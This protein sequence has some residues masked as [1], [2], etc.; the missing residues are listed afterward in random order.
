MK[1]LNYREKLLDPRWQQ[2]RLQVLARDG[3]KCRICEATDKTLHAH[4]S[5]Y[6][7]WAEGPWDYV[8]ETIITLCCDCHEEETE[9]LKSA[10]PMLAEAIASAGFVTSNHLGLLADVMNMMAMGRTDLSE[11]E[12]FLRAMKRWAEGGVE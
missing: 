11:R 2:M 10:K 4:H 6:L 1:A 5:I 8:P 3:W 12:T 9:C 7:P